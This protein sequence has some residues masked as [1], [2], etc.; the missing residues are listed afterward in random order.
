[1]KVIKNSLFL[2]RIISN[3]LP[4]DAKYSLKDRNELIK[5]LIKQLEQEALNQ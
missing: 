2:T 5:I 3:Q 1:M 4:A